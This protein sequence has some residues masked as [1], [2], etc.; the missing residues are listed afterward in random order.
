M[1]PRR[2]AFALACLGLFEPCRAAADTL[3]GI[4]DGTRLV[5]I[6]SA[7]PAGATAATI[8]GLAAGEVIR[9]LDVRP[10]DGR[11]YAITSAGRLCRIDVSS[12][13]SPQAV[14]PVVLAASLPAGPLGGD[15]DPARD[16]IRVI[17][18]D[19]GANLLIDPTTGAVAVETSI[20]S[21]A[22]VAGVAL[23]AAGE[24]SAG[25]VLST[26]LAIDTAQDRLAR[27]GA[28]SDPP[29]HAAGVVT[30]IGPLGIDAVGEVG[31]D[32]SLG[33]SGWLATTVAGSP[34]QSRLYRVALDTGAS[35]LLGV[36]GA[37]GPLGPVTSLTAA[38]PPTLQFS[39]GA[40]TLLETGGQA[41]LRIDR[42][43]D[44]SASVA[45]RVFTPGGTATNGIDYVAIDTQVVFPAGDATPRTVT[46]PIL[47]DTLIE[48]PETV[49]VTMTSPS[50]A[51]LGVPVI[52]VIT[53]TDVLPQGAPTLE[54]TTPGP[55]D[56]AQY[57]YPFATLAG[58]AS[59]LDGH[60]VEVSWA[61]SQGGSGTAVNPSHWFIG[62]I[63]LQFGSNIITLTALDSQGLTIS[64][65]IELRLVGCCSYALAEGATGSF[66]EYDLAIANPAASSAVYHASFS[67]EDGG[68]AFIDRSVAA[69]GR[70]TLRIDDE[71]P[72]DGGVS[73]A[74]DRPIR[75][76]DF[77]VPLLVERTM[78]WPDGLDY[79]AHGDKA[80]TERGRTWYFAEGSQGFFS[81]YLLLRNPNLQANRAVVDWLR[82]GQPPLRRVYALATNS[83]TTID[84]GADPELVGRSFGIVV[85]FDQ[86]GVAERAMYFGSSPAGP[87]SGGHA[88]AGVTLPSPRWF[89]AEGATGGFFTSFVL[90]ANPNDADATVH[91]R[92]FRLGG[93]PISRTV[94]VPA[95]GRFTLNLATVPGLENAA[96]STE[97]TSTLPVVAERA[98][99]WPGPPS[100]WYEAHNA[101][102]V[103]TLGRT[104]GLAEG[105][106]GNPAG[107]PPSAYQTYILLV[108]PGDQPATVRI[109][110]LRSDGM[111]PLEKTFVVPA[112]GRFN[113]R[114][115]GPETPSN[116]NVPELTDTTFGAVIS[117]S[118][119]IAVERAMYGNAPG[120]VWASGTDATAARL[121]DS[122]NASPATAR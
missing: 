17:A 14:T 79:G 73:A 121:P 22:I 92:F 20:A 24:D 66:F 60:V 83:R 61:N 111:P 76:L 1:R 90:V 12:P 43:G 35:T 72:R 29:S 25:N 67:F 6:D 56:L 64:R 41:S 118:R 30:A 53:I 82:E 101:F 45:V 112:T 115:A 2:L 78:R 89:L 59:D 80:V 97:V 110:F 4:V 62:D 100:D 65:Q 19:T 36:I 81:T 15:W 34:F 86:P 74:V 95:H 28:I 37:T 9:V 108:N 48:G 3:Y 27:V 122:L 94:S 77:S 103:H 93:A 39:A 116:D 38:L 119:P 40:H 44:A 88:S 84:A 117:A 7:A 91:L 69:L 47:A 42:L 8:G 63:P 49:T 99:Y 102:G 70:S 46:V 21:P 54:I 96:V 113:V 114:I 18:A 104:W 106:V 32:V 31:F 105:R 58:T 10:A 71:F 51:S 5:T 68:D 87:F 26:L 23:R 109:Q 107:F 50:G 52:A 98:Q 13:G 75:L 16:R 55:L 120:Q 11:L 33:G 57:T 85:T